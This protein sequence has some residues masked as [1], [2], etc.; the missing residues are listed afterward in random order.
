MSKPA[1]LSI[2]Q[3]LSEEQRSF[4]EN[5][6]PPEPAP[7][8]KPTPEAEPAPQQ[9]AAPRRRTPHTKPA[10]QP[11]APTPTAQPM[12]EPFGFAT[13]THRIRPAILQRLQ[14]AAAARKPLRQFPWTQQDIVEH[15]L[16]EWLSR[17]GFPINE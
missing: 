2:V 17:N 4:L 13:L 6:S 11:A 8:P 5:D 9:K 16:A 10:Q 15:A 1:R 12:A 14:Q 3:T 7:Q